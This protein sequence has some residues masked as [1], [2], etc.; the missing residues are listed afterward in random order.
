MLN[1]TTLLKLNGMFHCT[2]KTS[3]DEIHGLIKQN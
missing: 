1:K 3:S 2:Q